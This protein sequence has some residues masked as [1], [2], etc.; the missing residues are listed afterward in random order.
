M[1]SRFRWMPAGVKSLPVRRK[2]AAQVLHPDAGG[3]LHHARAGSLGVILRRA[4]RCLGRAFGLLEA[5]QLGTDEGAVAPL[6]LGR[7]ALD[8]GVVGRFG[9]AV[10][11]AQGALLQPGQHEEAAGGAARHAHA[12]YAGAE[13]GG[14]VQGLL[15]GEAIHIGKRRHDGLRAVEAAAEQLHGARYSVFK[16]HNKRPL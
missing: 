4:L 12:A 14:H 16:F 11:P 5:Q 7:Q 15:E 3:R 1:L 13:G 8:E 6:E 9:G 10:V 2:L